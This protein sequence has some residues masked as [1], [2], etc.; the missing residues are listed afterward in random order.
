MRGL[1]LGQEVLNTIQVWQYQ[2]CQ[3]WQGFEAG[4]RVG[5]GF[6][7]GFGFGRGIWG[8]RRRVWF[9]QAG[10]SNKL[11]RHESKENTARRAMSFN[12]Q[13]TRELVGWL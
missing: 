11:A 3:E 2:E 1:H 4:Q 5:F 8:H 13:Y 6:G 9:I 10:K 7:F 12:Q